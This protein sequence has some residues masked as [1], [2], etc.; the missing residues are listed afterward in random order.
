MRIIVPVVCLILILSAAVSYAQG[1]RT[2]KDWTDRSESWKYTYITG[3]LDGVTTGS[4]FTMPILSK[5]SIVLYKE[6][7]ACLEKAQ[8]TY[9]YNTS[10]FFFGITLREFVQGLDAFYQDPANRN[11]PINRAVQ[12]WAMQRKGVPEADKMLLDLRAQ[13][14]G[15]E[16]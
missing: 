15:S 5:G 6:D 10:R 4:D 3:L 1:E 9:G 2:G 16:N 14:S 11:I 8:S 12:V 13:W 7:N